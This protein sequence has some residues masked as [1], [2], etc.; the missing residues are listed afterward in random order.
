M[1]VRLELF[2]AGKA[3]LRNATHENMTHR[4]ERQSTETRQA[5]WPFGRYTHAYVCYN[6]LAYDLCGPEEPL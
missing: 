5:C 1:N 6:H 3:Q 2:E 4:Q